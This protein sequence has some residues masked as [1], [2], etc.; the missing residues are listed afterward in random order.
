MSK[1]LKNLFSKRSKP[2]AST[3][4][5]SVPLSSDSLSSNP[6]SSHQQD[7]ECHQSGALTTPTLVAPNN[8]PPTPADQA[9]SEENLQARISTAMPNKQ[10]NG[11]RVALSGL[12]HRSDSQ[13]N[14]AQVENGRMLDNNPPSV[15]SKGTAL[16]VDDVGRGDNYGIK[17]LYC[18]PSAS[19]DIVFV[20]GLTGN[21][22]TTWLHRRS[23]VHWPRDLVKYN[24]SDARVMTFGYDA[25][26]VNFWKHA[27][28][29]GIS[30][31]ANDLLASLAGCREI[32]IVCRKYS[33]PI[34][35]L[36]LKV[37]PFTCDLTITPGQPQDCFRCPQSWWSSYTTSSV[38]FT[39]KSLPSPQTD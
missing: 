30:G 39:G 24:L 29:D 26:V 2:T 13:R 18:P 33:S 28:Q 17:I 31:F 1:S 34:L 8:S 12:A 19:M 23:G 14:T 27:A 35:P 3:S 32:N 6:F 15:V 10:Q 20:H 16:G 21:A 5:S 4:S 36:N 11:W 7:G 37:R 9:G 38:S 22:Y 25:D